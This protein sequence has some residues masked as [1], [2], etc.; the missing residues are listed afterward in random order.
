MTTSAPEQSRAK[1]VSFDGD[2]L[3]VSLADGR[4]LH[5]PLAWMPRLR[6]ASH[7]ERADWR[8]I[9]GGTGIHWPALDEDVSVS[10]LL[11]PTSSKSGTD[12]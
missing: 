12:R 10:G 2:K 5:V 1:S 6:D 4:E 3:V 8:L 11:H 9:G 7:A